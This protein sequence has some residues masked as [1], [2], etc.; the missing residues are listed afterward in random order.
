MGV[1]MILL[2]CTHVFLNGMM[3]M[4]AGEPGILITHGFL[5]QWYF[6]GS[7]SSLGSGFIGLIG[8]SSGKSAGGFCGE[9]SCLTR[10]KVE[11]VMEGEEWRGEQ[12]LSLHLSQSVSQPLT[13]SDWTSLFSVNELPPICS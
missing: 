11:G 4:E 12:Y 10:G 13:L 6:T 1:N 8:A 7:I 3:W 2:H 9:R 5:N